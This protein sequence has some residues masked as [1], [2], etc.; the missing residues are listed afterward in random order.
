MLGREC[1]HHS[2]VEF[3]FDGIYRPFYIWTF[4]NHL[5][6]RIGTITLKTLIIRTG[7]YGNQ[8][9]D[10]ICRQTNIQKVA[11]KQD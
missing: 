11:K 5:A 7:I 6:V 8:W 2:P 9:T 1:R 4:L 3:N 10:S